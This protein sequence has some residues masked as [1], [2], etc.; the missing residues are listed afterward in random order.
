MTIILRPN[1]DILFMKVGVHANEPL[2]DIIARKTKEIEDTG[3]ALWGYGGNT[4]HP[5]MKVQP[6]A[7]AASAKQQPIYLCMESM[8]SKHFAEQIRADEFSVD[9]INFEKIPKTINVLGSRFALVIKNLHQEQ[10]DLPISRTKVAVGDCVGRAGGD[11]I[12]GRVDKACLTI[13]DN[14]KYPIDPEEKTVSISL[15]AE[16][17][18]PYAVFLK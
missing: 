6:F 5:T 11:Y 10:F 16:L 13:A 18:K 2:E 9:G 17:C 8:N 1:Q 15:V 14:I 12:K 4:C 3:Y 7:D